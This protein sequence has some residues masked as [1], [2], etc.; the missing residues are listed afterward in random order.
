MAEPLTTRIRS[1]ARRRAVLLGMVLVLTGCSGDPGTGPVAVKWDRDAC[2]RCNMVLSDRMHAAEV[3]Y[4][5]AGAT[6]S[7]VKKF[8]DL[9]CAM[10]WLDQQAWK[11]SPD[12]EIWVNDHRSGLWID[13]RSA[14]YVVGQ[15]T[16]MQYGLGA[17]IE[18]GPDTL[19]FTQA[20]VHINQVEQTHNVHGGGAHPPAGSE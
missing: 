20:R 15:H 7:E 13:A 19:D 16:P 5:P 12:V 8:D 11:D 9:G 4:T 10:L 6:H 1:R 17:Q 3:R 2:A 18:A 14:H